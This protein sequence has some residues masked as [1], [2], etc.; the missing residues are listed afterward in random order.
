MKYIKSYSALFES[1]K[2][3][4]PAAT[5]FMRELEKFPL[6]DIFKSWFT[7]TP[8]KT[9]RISISGG[10]LPS[11]QFEASC[12]VY[13]NKYGDLQDLFMEIIKDSIRKAAPSYLRKKELDDVLMDDDWLS[14]NLETD[15][16]S[17]YPKIKSRIIG[18]SDIVSNFTK[19]VFPRLKTLKELGLLLGEGRFFPEGHGD[20]GSIAFYMVTKNFSDRHKPKGIFWSL[21]DKVVSKEDHEY[22]TKL[23]NVSSIVFY[24][25]GSGVSARSTN[26]RMQ[27]D[28]GV[29]DEQEAVDVIEK[30]VIKYML[31]N[32]LIINDDVSEETR[33]FVNNLYH[34]FIESSVSG[35]SI[36]KTLDDYFKNNPLD[37]WM[38]DSDPRLKAGVLKRTGLRDVSG[39]GRNLNLGVL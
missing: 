30:T 7:V 6:K 31:K 12:K 33:N 23:S 28:V 14:A 26:T 11:K 36:D 10:G 9:G 22:Y 25:K 13:G 4:N 3:L 20:L 8:R 16:K 37:L 1:E 5:R 34:Q 35:E 21:I 29:K 17:I 39:L 32:R 18:D 19:L 15:P 27:I 38:L 24:P 2:P